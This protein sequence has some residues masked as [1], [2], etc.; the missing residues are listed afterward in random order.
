MNA[1][2]NEELKSAKYRHPKL[3]IVRTMEVA[4]GTRVQIG[5]ELLRLE[6]DPRIQ[7]ILDECEKLS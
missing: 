2:N 7:K 1:E 5:T 6:N 3:G 4:G